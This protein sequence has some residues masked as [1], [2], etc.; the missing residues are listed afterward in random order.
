MMHPLT[1]IFRRSNWLQIPKDTEMVDTEYLGSFLC[2][3]KKTDL[4]GPVSKAD[5]F[6]WSLSTANNQAT[7]S[8]SSR[9]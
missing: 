7:H 2:S 1:E 9:F 6:C 8:S 5:T 3:C 4:D